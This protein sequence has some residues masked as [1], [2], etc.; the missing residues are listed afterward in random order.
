M[1]RLDIIIKWNAEASEELNIDL[2]DITYE[3]IVEYLLRKEVKTP[4]IIIPSVEQM[5][6]QRDKISKEYEGDYPDLIEEGFEM[7][8]DW[9]KNK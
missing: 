9:I 8:Y 2:G 4:S 5:E 3:N 7:C 6:V 1:Y